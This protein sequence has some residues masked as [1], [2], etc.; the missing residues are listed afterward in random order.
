[1]DT[2]DK[3]QQ[4]NALA[5]QAGI[6]AIRARLAGQGRD[7]CEDCGEGIPAPRRAANPSATRCVYCQ[8]NHEKRTK[9]T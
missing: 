4:Q 9:R 8:A 6:D 3:A 2:V 5:E 7:Y 1:M